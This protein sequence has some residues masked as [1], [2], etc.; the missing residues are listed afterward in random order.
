MEKKFRQLEQ[1][2]VKEVDGVA[3]TVE[4][5]TVKFRKSVL[6]RFPFL[7]ISLSTF[8]VVAVLYGDGGADGDDVAAEQASELAGL[9]LQLGLVCHRRE[10]AH[11]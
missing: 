10:P 1:T 2:V 5:T 4:K 11:R 7:I 9:A 3:Q 6:E 8:G